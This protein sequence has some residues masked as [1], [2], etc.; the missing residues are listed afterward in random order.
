[1]GKQSAAYGWSGG[2]SPGSPVFAFK[3]GACCVFFFVGLWTVCHGL[4]AFRIGVIGRL[5]SVIVAVPRHLLY[6]FCYGIIDYV[7][8]HI[9]FN[10]EPASILPKSVLDLCR[11]DRTG[12]PSGGYM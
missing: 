5:H 4:F 12:F 8:L 7:T 9:L 1:M 3:K 10:S 2:F 11:P 6:F